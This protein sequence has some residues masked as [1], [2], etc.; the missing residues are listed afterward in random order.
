M[1]IGL[2]K[3]CDTSIWTI[4]LC[5]RYCDICKDFML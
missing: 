5:I 2:V 3:T 4:E 1:E